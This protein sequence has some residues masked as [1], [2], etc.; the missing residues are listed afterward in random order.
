M[1]PS[2]RQGRTGA[3]ATQLVTNPVQ[4][5]SKLIQAFPRLLHIKPQTLGPFNM[6]QRHVRHHPESAQNSP[7]RPA[8]GAI[9]NKATIFHKLSIHAQ[10]DLIELGDGR[11][12][13][14]GGSDHI[15]CLAQDS[16][17]F[18]NSPRPKRSIYPSLVLRRQPMSGSDHATAPVLVPAAGFCP[19]PNTARTRSARS[20][21]VRTTP[22]RYESLRAT[23]SA[24][25]PHDATSQ[26][27]ESWTADGSSMS[28]TRGQRN[29]PPGPQRL[30]SGHPTKRRPR[31]ERAS[32]GR[33][34]PVGV[35]PSLA[36]PLE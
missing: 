36:H 35:N 15:H 6:S 23:N 29:T 14:K 3:F 5:R 34:T 25:P 28:G 30:T 12:L 20:V 16:T 10:E 7:V 32:P 31:R 24:S 9:G 21:S 27:S 17:P 8:T 1:Q 22:T 13:T 33:C 19:L 18:A 4:H 2:E 26:G 11:D